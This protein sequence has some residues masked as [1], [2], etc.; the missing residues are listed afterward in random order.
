MHT[1]HNV[2][3]K[4]SFDIQCTRG[5]LL[6]QEVLFRLIRKVSMDESEVFEYLKCR[7]GAI[8]TI[9]SLIVTPCTSNFEL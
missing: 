3:S 2:D 8:F 7:G 1:L 5:P 9:D 6:S 4:S